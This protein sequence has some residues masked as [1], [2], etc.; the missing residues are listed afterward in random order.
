[1]FD[2]IV[3]DGSAYD[4]AQFDRAPEVVLLLLTNHRVRIASA[5]DVILRKL[6]SAA[7]PSRRRK[8]PGASEPVAILS[9]S[10]KH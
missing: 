4:R 8:S 9:G 10:A 5:E 3:S 2:P 7:P 1:M 6:E